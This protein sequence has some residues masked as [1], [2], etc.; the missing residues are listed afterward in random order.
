MGP[1]LYFYSLNKHRETLR[2]MGGEALID[3][4]VNPSEPEESRVLYLMNF[5]VNKMEQWK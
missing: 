3:F 2:I 4:F 5:E 1:A